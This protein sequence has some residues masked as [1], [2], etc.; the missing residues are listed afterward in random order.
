MKSKTQLI[1]GSINKWNKIV[2]G[3]EADK[4]P[5]NCAL[6]NEFLAKDCVGCPVF[7]RTGEPLCNGTPY[8]HFGQVFHDELLELVRWHINPKQEPKVVIGP[9]TM[10]V[11]CAE[12]DFIVSLLESDEKCTS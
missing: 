3:L 2:Q 9:K 5:E 11:A 7:E 10:E 8:E 4:G 6:C 12:H 1:Q